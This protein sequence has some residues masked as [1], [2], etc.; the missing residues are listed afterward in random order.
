MPEYERIF[1]ETKT[2]AV[3]GLSPDPSRDSLHV[4]AYLQQR[5][6]RIIPVNPQV[7][8][9]LG[10]KAYPDLKSVPGSVDMVDVF[11]RSEFLPGIVEDAIAKGGVK[12]IWTQYGVVH[13]GAA[14]RAR[15]AGIKVVQ[16]RC[17]LVEHRRLVR[18]GVLPSR[19]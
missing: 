12:T 11:R 19:A 1:R 8:E 13:D 9:V 3:V 2:I 18:E 16:D 15:K 5:G 6:Y 14:E 7:T 10:E 17:A 4:A